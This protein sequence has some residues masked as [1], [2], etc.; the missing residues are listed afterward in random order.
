[1]LPAER[2]RRV[3]PDMGRGISHSS[4]GIRAAQAP[5]EIVEIHVCVVLEQETIANVVDSGVCDPGDLDG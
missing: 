3:H 5:P 4:S 1:M 2:K